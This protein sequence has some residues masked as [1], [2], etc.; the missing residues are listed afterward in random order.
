MIRVAFGINVAVHVGALRVFGHC[1]ARVAARDAQ[2]CAGLV[3]WWCMDES[4]SSLEG[5]DGRSKQKQFVLREMGRGEGLGL[6]L[7]LASSA[8]MGGCTGCT[9]VC[10]S[11]PM[12]VH[13]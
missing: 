9:G 8:S 3:R 12:V 4:A 5:L 13:G 7:G 11:R 10:G 2:V 1:L 6:A